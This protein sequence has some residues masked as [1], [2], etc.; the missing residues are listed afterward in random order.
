MGNNRAI[1]CK[2]IFYYFER[3]I[4]AS[5]VYNDGFKP[6]IILSKQTARFSLGF[7]LN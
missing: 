7:F 4:R 2:E 3:S 1:Q 6:L 5:T